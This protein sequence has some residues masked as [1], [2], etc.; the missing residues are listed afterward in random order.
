MGSSNYAAL[1]YKYRAA[2]RQADS[3]TQCAEIAHGSK[4]NAFMALNTRNMQ[5]ADGFCRFIGNAL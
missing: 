2:L 3:R 5:R 1:Q 4:K